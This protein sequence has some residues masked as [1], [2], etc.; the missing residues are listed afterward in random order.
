MYLYNCNASRKAPREKEKEKMREREKNLVL[1][2]FRKCISALYNKREGYEEGE[3][4]EERKDE[5]RDKFS[6]RVARDAVSFL[7]GETDL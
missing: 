6:T 4:E 3:E 7:L 5:T 2:F 1:Y